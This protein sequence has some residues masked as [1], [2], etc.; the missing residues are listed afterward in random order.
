M[1]KLSR[2]SINKITSESNTYTTNYTYTDVANVTNKTT[3]L[4]KTIK[5]ENVE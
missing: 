2:L 4:L 5:N 1:D 3:T